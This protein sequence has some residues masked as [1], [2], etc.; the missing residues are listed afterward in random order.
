M[1]TLNPACSFCNTRRQHIRDSTNFNKRRSPNRT[2]KIPKKLFHCSSA[3]TGYQQL[4]QRKP[5]L[6]KKGKQTRCHHQSFDN[7]PH[8]QSAPKSR[9]PDRQAIEIPKAT[10]NDSEQHSIDESIVD[11]SRPAVYPEE[12]TTNQPKSPTNVGFP[13]NRPILRKRPARAVL[14][15]LIPET[16]LPCSQ[17]PVADSGPTPITSRS[18]LPVPFLPQRQVTFPR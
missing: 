11:G 8:L 6:P 5:S 17:L 15:Q 4:H 14:D 13:P 9:N 18:Q 10:T 16:N 7:P 2:K 12:Q 1:I 3:T